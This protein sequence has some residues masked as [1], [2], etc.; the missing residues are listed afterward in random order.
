MYVNEYIQRELDRSRDMVN[1]TMKDMTLELFNWAPPGTA[2]TI[3]ATFIHFVNVED[4][5]IQEKLQ[6]KPS[7]W[8]RTRIQKPPGIGEDWSEYKRK[9]IDIQPLLGYKDEV[10]AATDAYLAS[11]KAEELDRKVKLG[12][13]ERTV[14]DVLVLSAS[15]SLNHAG[16]IAALKGIQGAKG[17][18]N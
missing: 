15:Q 7:I 4:L 3:S 2:N 13:K 9:Q 14:A 16:E 11:L 10:W 18:P 17:L 5:L 12:G 8:K 1:R 6:D